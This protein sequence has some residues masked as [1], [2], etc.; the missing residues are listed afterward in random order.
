MHHSLFFI[1]IRISK[2]RFETRDV[3]SRVKKMKI[4]NLK[5]IMFF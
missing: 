5:T 4:E 3:Q 2:M 1:N